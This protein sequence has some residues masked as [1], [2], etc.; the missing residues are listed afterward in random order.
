MELQKDGGQMRMHPYD[1]EKHKKVMLI[2]PW[3]TNGII[4]AEYTV[5]TKMRNTR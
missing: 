4:Y 2:T 1:P 5:S 3:D